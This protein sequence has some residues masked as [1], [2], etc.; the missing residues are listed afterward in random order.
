MA[1]KVRS[2]QV[3]CGEV[4]CGTVWQVWFGFVFAF[5]V[6]MI[7]GVLPAYRAASLKAVDALRWE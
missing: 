5:V 4:W 7:S 6:G 2:G 3:R 1:G